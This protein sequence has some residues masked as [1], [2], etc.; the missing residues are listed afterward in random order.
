MK[1]RCP[2]ASLGEGGER[3]SASRSLKSGGSVLVGHGGSRGP[4]WGLGSW[5]ISSSGQE[6]SQA[7]RGIVISSPVWRLVRQKNYPV[8][9]EREPF[10]LSWNLLEDREWHCLMCCSCVS[11]ASQACAIQMSKTL[12]VL[13]SHYPFSTGRPVVQ[14]MIFFLCGGSERPLSQMIS[15]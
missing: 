10:I 1:V 8:G 9:R 14:G 13:K 7:L 6:S 2:R 4:D 12:E 5:Q 15:G 11:P 3:S